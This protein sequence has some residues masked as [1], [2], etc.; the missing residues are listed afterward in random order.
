MSKIIP[1]LA[2][3]YNTYK[4]SAKTSEDK[5]AFKDVFETYFDVDNLIDYLILSDVLANYD[6]FSQ[7]VQW[8]TYDGVKWYLCAYDLDG[9]MGNW[10]Q[11]NDTIV[12]PQTSHKDYIQFHYLPIFYEEELETR[13]A[14]LR[15]L[16]ILSVEHIYSLVDSWLKRVGS[17]DMFE[18]EW[19]KW[20]GFIKNDNMHRLYKWLQVSILNMDSLYNYN[21]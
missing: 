4:E 19:L 17:K 5:A 20:P 6:G 14:E 8:I 12:S 13:Y 1:T 11:L 16:G 21:Q 7:N 9:V 3:A 2:D 10:W 18:K 15:N